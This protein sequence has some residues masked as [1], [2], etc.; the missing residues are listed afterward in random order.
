MLAFAPTIA[1]KLT[2]NVS[3][4]LAAQ[5]YYATLDLDIALPAPGPNNDNG[6][7]TLDG[8]DTGFS[9][10]LGIAWEVSERTRIGLD[11]QAEV[12]L[13]FDGKLKANVPGIRVDSNTELPLAAKVRLGINH[14][15]D[16][17]IGFWFS[18][19]WDDWSALDEVFVSLPEREGG[20]KKNWDDT[21]HYAAGFQYRLDR[22]WE[23]A[24]GIAY[25]TNPVDST[26]RTADLP[27]DRQIRY[28][29]GARYTLRDG[30]TIGGY[31]NYT[32][33][34]SAKI[35][36]RFWSGEYDKNSAIELGINA[37]WTF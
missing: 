11:Y 35:D 34:G 23:I 28:N 13:D 29:A 33:L 21:Y 16:D 2:D 4:G 27:V 37:N 25:D 19:G 32:D 12:D 7:A 1:Y 36:A 20:L 24:S 5:G 3:I 8:D 18:L 10:N 30:L 26:D 31:I 6:K 9:Y 15:L 17:Q 22:N 14:N